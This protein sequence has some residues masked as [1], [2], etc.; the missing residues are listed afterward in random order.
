MLRAAR[1]F[2]I[3][4]ALPV[5]GGLL[6]LRHRRLLSVA[7]APLGLNILLYLGTLWL[8]TQYYE[9]WFSVLW[10][11][12]EAWYWHLGY[13]LVRFGAL[14]LVI[15]GLLFS[16]V[17]VGTAIA[18]PFLDVLSARVEQMAPGPHAPERAASRSWVR[19]SVRALGQGLLLGGVWLAL[20]PLSFLPGL[21]QVLWLLLNWLL[22]AYNF[23][24]FALARRPWP[25]REQW[26]RLRYHW[27]AALGFGAAVFCCAVIPLL[28]LVLLPVAVS[29]GTLLVQ[30]LDAVPRQ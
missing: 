22:L 26:R 20:L 6:L 11:A 16:F 17:V 30:R 9:Q 28:G 25:V 23:A 29:G 24:A 18:A 1:G 10:P 21:G 13:V 14:V 4:F 12:P 3:G 7:L 8:L 5:S 15:V 2:L 19:E 27:A